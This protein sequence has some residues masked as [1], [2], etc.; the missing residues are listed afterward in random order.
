MRRDS[1]APHT[2]P[3]RL[4]WCLLMCAC[5]CTPLGWVPTVFDQASSWE[6]ER[7]S[8]CERP[9]SNM[10]RALPPFGDVVALEALQA[11][12][13]RVDAVDERRRTALYIAAAE[14]RTDV[15]QW[16]LSS[17]ADP[18]M[19]ADDGRTALHAAAANGHVD[20]CELLLAGH[21]DTNRFIQ[22]L[23]ARGQSAAQLASSAQ[24]LDVVR[25]LLAQHR[26]TEERLRPASVQ[27]NVQPSWHAVS[28][29]HSKPDDELAIFASPRRRFG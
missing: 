8:S 4:R 19:C 5:L 15:V 16:L 27:V 20:A 29:L 9:Y 6:R 13:A 1:S 2:T 26:L 22:Q 18:L 25:V 21:S 3:G 11:C 23:D 28:V 12:G 17:K 7:T 14:G 10:H 24:H